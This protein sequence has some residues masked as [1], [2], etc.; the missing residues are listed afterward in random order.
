MC[1]RFVEKRFKIEHRIIRTRPSNGQRS[2]LK[3]VSAAVPGDRS[4]VHAPGLALFGVLPR[5]AVQLFFIDAKS[6]FHFIRLES[7]KG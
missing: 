5:Q 4:A 2:N 7:S 1:S 3:N 6:I